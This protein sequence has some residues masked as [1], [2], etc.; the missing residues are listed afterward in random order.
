MKF[1][2]R[3][4]KATAR[5]GIEWSQTAIG[6]ALGVSKQTADRWM[7]DGQPAADTIF[8][9]ADALKVDARWLATEEGLM[10]ATQ[11]QDAELKRHS[12]SDAEKLLVVLRTFLDT[13]AVG[14]SQLLEAATAV[15]KAHGAIPNPKPTS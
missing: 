10:V 2:E 7:G 3:L 5:A 8:K 1:S 9:V 4:K 6:K 12:E 13:D 11:E 15:S 14:R